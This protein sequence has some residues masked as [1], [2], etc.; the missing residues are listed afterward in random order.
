MNPVP[1]CNHHEITVEGCKVYG[2]TMPDFRE[3]EEVQGNPR[4]TRGFAEGDNISATASQQ[5]P[6]RH[7][8]H[9]GHHGT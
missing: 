9:T 7:E 6:R 1:N 3:H 2:F 5:L 4:D 8:N